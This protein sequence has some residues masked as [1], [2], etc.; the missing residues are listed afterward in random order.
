MNIFDANAIVTALTI[1]DA[2]AFDRII[3]SR[4]IPFGTAREPIRSDSF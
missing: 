3:I 1:A 4:P 2:L